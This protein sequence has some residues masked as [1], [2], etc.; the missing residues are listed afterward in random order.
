MSEHS[1]LLE[2]KIDNYFPEL[3]IENCDIIWNPFSSLWTSSLTN[4]TRKI[5]KL[6][7]LPFWSNIPNSVQLKKKI[8]CVDTFI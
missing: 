3:K 5:I 4:A 7:I 8:Y 1:I 6:T 2:D